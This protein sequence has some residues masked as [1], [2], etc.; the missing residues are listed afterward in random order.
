MKSQIVEYFFTP[1]HEM[2]L[3]GHATIAMLYA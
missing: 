3:C 2:N 1:G